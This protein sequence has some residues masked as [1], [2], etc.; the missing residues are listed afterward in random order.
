MAIRAGSRLGPIPLIHH[1]RKGVA[2]IHAGV[3]PILAVGIHMAVN[4]RHPRHRLLV[5]DTHAACPLLDIV[6]QVVCIRE[7]EVAVALTV[8]PST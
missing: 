5:R 6:A 8:E 7:T 4:A 3:T 2:C 1:R